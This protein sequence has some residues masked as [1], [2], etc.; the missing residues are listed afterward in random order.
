MIGPRGRVGKQRKNGLGKKASVGCAVATR[1]QKRPKPESSSTL[2][3]DSEAAAYRRRRLLFAVATLIISRSR[4]RARYHAWVLLLAMSCAGVPATL[5]LVSV[6]PSAACCTSSAC[7]RSN[8]LPA[9]HSAPAGELCRG[10]KHSGRSRQALC[11]CSLSQNPSSLVATT[12]SQFCLEPPRAVLVP[13][14]DPL[15]TLGVSLLLPLPNGHVTPPD[16]PPR[17]Q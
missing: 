14:L 6:H 11:T 17:V 3:G 9:S 7:C 12:H 2:Y 10:A 5:G 4:M 15:L 16:Q 13:A 1:R 8:C